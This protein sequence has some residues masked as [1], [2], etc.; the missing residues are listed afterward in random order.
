MNW[1][2]L[3]TVF[4]AIIA[5]ASLSFAGTYPVVSASYSALGADTYRVTSAPGDVACAPTVSGDWIYSGAKLI[6]ISS[7]SQLFGG[8][9]D[10]MSGDYYFSSVL[11]DPIGLTDVPGSLNGNYNQTTDKSA[12]KAKVFWKVPGRDCYNW[13]D[14]PYQPNGA[15][16]PTGSACMIGVPAANTPESYPMSGIWATQYPYPGIP[17]GAVMLF[18]NE[19]A[20]SCGPYCASWE[21]GGVTV[22]ADNAS[23][24]TLRFKNEGAT[25]AFY[26]RAIGQ[27]QFVP[28]EPQF[29]TERGS[30]WLSI[31]TAD[32]SFQVA[33]EIAKPEFTFRYLAPKPA[34]IYKF[35][36]LATDT[37]DRT[38]LNR[39][40]TLPEDEYPATLDAPDI[41]AF[42]SPLRAVETGTTKA[43]NLFRIGGA[44]FSGFADYDVIDP[45]AQEGYIG[46]QAYWAG[47]TPNAVSYDPSSG[48][49]EVIV[50]RYSAMAYSEKFNG[51]DFGI[52][53]C[54]GD[55]NYT[56]P[57]DWASCG[58]LSNSRTD[59]H[60]VPV[61][62]M[63]SKWIISK[64]IAPEAQL[65][66]STAA[67]NGGQIKLAKERGYGILEV[68]QILDDT[69]FGGYFKIRLSGIIGENT[70]RFDILDPNEVMVGQIQLDAGTTYTFTQSGTGQVLMLHLYKVIQGPQ[71]CA[72]AA[73]CGAAEISTYSEEI[74]LK[75]WSRYNLVNSTH[76]DRDFK[77]S[78]LWK[79][80]D[81]A[82]TG[83]STQ[84]DSL[85]EV[86]VYN[87]DSFTD[88]TLMG[89]RFD[90]LKSKPVFSLTYS[91]ITPKAVSWTQSAAVAKGK[92]I[93]PAGN[94]AAG[95]VAGNARAAA[96]K[97]K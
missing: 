58:P 62:F 49:Q 74:T 95:A 31:G 46:Q 29:V 71:E 39:Q 34:G 72:S 25:G 79:N 15:L 14:M 64:M 69:Y 70:A 84:P 35:N 57:D 27:E 52:P 12:W 91:G 22:I 96:P 66:S 89:G 41:G 75:D 45:Q 30:R 4:A 80:R 77:V 53:V 13:N 85:R 63:G 87:T 17:E 11:F 1:K 5:L 83:S 6:K 7:G 2:I 20:G 86:V 61:K 88:K 73:G 42:T 48:V 76:P 3:G 55:L 68:N 56:T 43:K 81:Y 26:Y 24:S 97:K 8:P 19:F 21:T 54:T 59:S 94:A 33:T 51:N 37:L 18:F 82:G 60:R 93:A 50:N 9:G 40:N 32:V 47:S 92:R 10:V 44:E 28:Y 65:A 38:L 90:F 67:I 16:C 23:L 78:L 36:T